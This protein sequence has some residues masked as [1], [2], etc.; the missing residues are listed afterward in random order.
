MLAMKKYLSRI[1]IISI[2]PL[3]M[4]IQC[5]DDDFCGFDSFEGYP[6]SL[7][8]AKASYAINDTIWVNGSTSS[9]QPFFCEGDEELQ[10]NLDQNTFQD[11]FFPLKLA[12]SDRTNAVVATADFDFVIDLGDG[13]DPDFCLDSYFVLPNLTQNQEQ[14][15]FRVGIVPKALGSYAI[16]SVFSSV[17]IDT[18]NLNLEVFQ[19]FDGFEDS[20][21]FE[22]CG[23]IYTRRNSD[24]SN[25]FF[26]VD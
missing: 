21:K 12:N 25:F 5:E 9:E 15:Q 8:N 19:A 7:E 3:L 2:A 17:F 26:T 4:A 14:Y 20:I 11:A 23:D 6:L 1:W 13:Y 16:T 24:L 18:T 10:I 22:N